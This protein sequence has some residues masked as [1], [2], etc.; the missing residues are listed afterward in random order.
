M[1]VPMVFN[2]AA[3]TRPVPT[4]AVTRNDH[5]AAFSFTDRVNSKLSNFHG[6]FMEMRSN[7][8]NLDGYAVWSETTL[9]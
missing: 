9:I 2:E 7:L 6:F 3:H 4:R 5:Q 1:N 8:G